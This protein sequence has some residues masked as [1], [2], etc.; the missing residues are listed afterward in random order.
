MTI[1][2]CFQTKSNVVNI[3]RSVKMSTVLN[4]ETTEEDVNTHLCSWDNIDPAAF[5]PSPLTSV[6]Y[7]VT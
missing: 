6:T 7:A 3:A 2:P 5:S 4:D 1:F